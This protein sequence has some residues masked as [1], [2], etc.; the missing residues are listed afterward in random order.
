[1]EKV[2]IVGA[3]LVGSLLAVYFGKKGIPV[4]VY[5]QRPDMRKTNIA[6]GRSINLACSNR[7]WKALRK[8]GVEEQ[9][10]SSSI[11]MKG[12]MIHS[13]EGELTFQPYG[14][15][16]EAIYSVSRGELN[17]ILLDHAEKTLMSKFVSMKN[18]A[19]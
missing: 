5:E 12:R 6:A 19:I 15:K 8:V 17:K 7:G 13:V 16:D 9:V 1:M 11:P 14:K 18:A 3:G 4:R 2:T 10:K